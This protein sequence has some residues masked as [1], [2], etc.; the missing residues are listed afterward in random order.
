MNHFC[1]TLVFT[2]P[3]RSLRRCDDRHKYLHAGMRLFL[4]EVTSKAQVRDANMAVFV[5]QD[6]SWLRV[7]E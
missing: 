7:G 5:Q 1:V 2:K 3:S 6:I 4:G